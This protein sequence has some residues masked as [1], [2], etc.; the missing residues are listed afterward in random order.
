MGVDALAF[1]TAL[2]PALALLA[3]AGGGDAPAPLVAPLLAGRRADAA[4]G[5]AAPRDDCD[6]GPSP[7][8]MSTGG[9][10]AG[11][12]LEA[13]PPGTPMLLPRPGGAV[14]GG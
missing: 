11:V 13:A 4:E 5:E 9:G 10:A 7:A 14:S 3:A 6:V 8:L 12:P 2:A 1:A